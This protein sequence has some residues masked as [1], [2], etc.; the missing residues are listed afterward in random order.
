MIKIFKKNSYRLSA[1]ALATLRLA[2]VAF[3]TGATETKAAS[4][5]DT[6]TQ[7]IVDKIDYPFVDDEDAVGKWE[8]VDFVKEIE[9]FNV[10]ETSWQGDLYLKSINLLPNGQMTQPVASG[11]TSDETT[12][13]DWLTTSTLAPGTR[14]PRLSRT[15]PPMAPC[16]VWADA[17]IVNA[18]NA[19]AELWSGE[20]NDSA[21]FAAEPMRNRL[22]K[23]RSSFL[24]C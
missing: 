2:G 23:S 18:N 10:N 13:V 8:T 21:T 15:E 20:G 16:P 14:A 24:L 1:F 9:D 11:I 3:L 5:E 17:L 12:P 19:I 6:S 7:Q 4:T 22:I